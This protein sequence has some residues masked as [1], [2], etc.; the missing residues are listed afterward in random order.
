[1]QNGHV[2]LVLCFSVLHLNMCVCV[3][4]CVWGGGGAFCFLLFCFLFSLS[5]SLSLVLC[6]RVTP[7]VCS[8]PGAS[9]VR[10]V[11]LKRE[12]R[13]I[14]NWVFEAR[15]RSFLPTALQRRAAGFPRGHN[16]RRENLPPGPRPG[17]RPMS[18]MVATT[19]GLP[20]HLFDVLFDLRSF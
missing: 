14:L 12:G 20:Q 3:C 19:V 17:I 7:S 5:L 8:Q 13:Q 11:L 10:G 6:V 9:T 2:F 16:R 18:P 15:Y 1:M 4:V